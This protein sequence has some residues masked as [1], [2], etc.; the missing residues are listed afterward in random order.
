MKNEIEKEY[1]KLKKEISW[2]YKTTDYKESD[3]MLL[4][5]FGVMLL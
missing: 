3:K 4:E 5:R 2:R 1:E